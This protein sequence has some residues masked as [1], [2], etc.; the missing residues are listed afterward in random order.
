V[1][2]VPGWTKDLY[3]TVHNDDESPFDGVIAL[4]RRCIGFGDENARAWARLIDRQEVARLGPW[5]E[6]IARSIHQEMRRLAPEFGC[7]MLRI[8]LE[9]S[10]DEQAPPPRK[11]ALKAFQLLREHFSDWNSDELLIVKREFPVYLRVDVHQAVEAM[12]AAA[13]RVGV[14]A[15][16]RWDSTDM[17]SLLSDR[18]QPRLVGA[19]Q[20]EDIDI[21]EDVP[22]RVATNCLSLLHEAGQPFALWVNVR[23]EHGEM[24]QVSVEILAAPGEAA[25]RVT[26]RM[27]DALE[28]SVARGAS[29]RGKVLSLESSETYRGMSA[30]A[31][32]VHHRAAVSEDELILSAAVRG[33]IDRHLLGFA[34][35]RKALQ[36]LGQ[37]GRK[38]VLLHGPPGTGKTHTI[39][40]LAQ[41][42]ADHTT[43]LVTAEQVGL[44]HVHFRL[45]RLFAP[46]ILVIEDA[47]LIAR[48]R[49]E[50][51]SACDEVMLNRLL[52]EM[53]GLR[54]DAEVFVIMTTN[55]P[56]DDEPS[57]NARGR[58][59][60]APGTD[61]PRDRDPGPRSRLP[62][63]AAEALRR[64]PRNRRA[65][66]R[67]AC[68]A[69]GG[70]ERRVHQG[71]GA[72]PGAGI[73]PPGSARTRPAGRCRSGT[74]GDAQRTER[75]QHQSAGCRPL[76]GPGRRPAP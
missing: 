50:M 35:S 34:A 64:F 56:D 6:P 44:I 28:A 9:D 73:D 45:A 21:G 4:L 16:N 69:H 27:L 36:E 76:S 12:V 68:G 53:D 15:H 62:R 47:D 70:G 33:A 46:S 57:R 71:D 20:F 60:A 7:R 13:R 31:L 3:L 59:R 10:P 63:A 32:T 74:D 23:G 24:P 54:A 38:G 26:S 29:Y 72:A 51:S 43:F 48:Q 5:S 37:S 18:N 49:D 41:K 11:P 22:V 25:A 61:R 39:R 66:G 65:R 42:L 14:H 55:R 30:N 40:Y 17:A 75:H 2:D 1:K 67:P 58:P 19:L 52:N 8:E